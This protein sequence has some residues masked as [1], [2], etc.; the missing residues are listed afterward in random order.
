MYEYY[1]GYIIREGNEGISGEKLRSLY[2]A[3]GWIS[4]DMPLWQNEKY[5]IALQNSAWAFTVWYK[6]E[7]IGLVRV[8]SDKVMF[9]SIQD[10]MV[11]EAHRK[12][13]IGRKLVELCLHKLPHGGWFA[14][15]DPENYDF[16]K[17]LG[18]EM[19]NSA[20]SETLVY[21]GFLKARRE[22]HR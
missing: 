4:K 10:L 17:H 21:N 11:L 19:P 1:N 20:V 12:K 7:L 22:G 2:E 18:F 8:I 3:I 14:Q 13:G 5:E 6:D 9:A 16:Y 15:T